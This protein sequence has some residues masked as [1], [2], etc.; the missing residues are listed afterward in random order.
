MPARSKSKR[1]L[2]RQKRGQNE[3]PKKVGYLKYF[4]IALVLVGFS[5][6]VGRAVFKPIPY[7]MFSVAVANKDGT[8]TLYL[9]DFYSNTVT[10]INLPKNLQVDMSRQR[11]D[12]KLGSVWQLIQTED[13]GGEVY[14]DSMMKT[15]EVPLERWA[16][17]DAMRFSGSN[18][19]GSLRYLIRAGQTD[20]TLSERVHLMMFSAGLRASERITIDVLDTGALHKTNLPDGEEGYLVRNNNISG[21]QKYFVDPDISGLLLRVGILDKSESG[22]GGFRKTFVGTIENM[23]TKVVS[24]QNGNNNLNLDGCEVK[25]PSVNVAAVKLAEVYNCDVVESSTENFD[26]IISVGEEFVRDH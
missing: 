23:G 19:V 11:G 13:L 24:V 26:M 2:L 8:G 15:L 9:A 18:F 17:E 4:L 1:R 12:W 14:K 16:S 10:E 7:S 3:K 5:F 20:L 21:L 25:V 22:L 6:L